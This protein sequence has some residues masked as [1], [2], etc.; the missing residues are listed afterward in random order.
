MASFTHSIPVNTSAEQLWAL[1]SDVNRVAGLFPYTTLDDFTTPEQ[2]HW[3]YWRRLTIP[4]VADLHWRED[5]CIT[6]HGELAFHAVDGDLQTFT[7]RWAVT[8]DGTT[9]S[10][11]LNLE[12]EIPQ[13]LA[14]SLPGALVGYVMGEIFKSICQ[15][16]KEAAEGGEV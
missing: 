15:R 8:S 10:L 2:N 13:G 14:P 12:Y 16:I 9:P 3:L 5:A 11:T 7:G 6:N 1:V 4:N